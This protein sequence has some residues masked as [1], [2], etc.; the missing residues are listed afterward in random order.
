MGGRRGRLDYALVRNLIMLSQMA[1]RTILFGVVQAEFRLCEDRNSAVNTA[2]TIDVRMCTA[3]RI[4]A[5]LYFAKV[6]VAC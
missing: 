4:Q 6:K 1:P 5:H 2:P 3:G